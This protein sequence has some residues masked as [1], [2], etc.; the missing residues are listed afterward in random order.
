MPEDTKVESAPPS[1]PPDQKAPEQK[2]P[3]LILGKFKS[4][5][6][7]AASY[8]S[9]EAKLGERKPEPL[10]ISEPQVDDDAGIAKTVE[11]VGLGLPELAAEFSKSGKLTDDQYAKFK[12]KGF[13]RAYV[14]DMAKGLV[15]Q[16]ALRASH[17]AEAVRSA[18]E[19][20]GGTDKLDALLKEAKT[21][22]NSAEIPDFERRINDPRLAS[23]AVR[24]LAARHREAV[25]AGKAKPLVEGAPSSGSS[26]PKTAK[27]AMSLAE[28]VFK[29]DP[30]AIKIMAEA[31]RTGKTHEWSKN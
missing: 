17:Q 6:D 16:E 5:E 24:D 3:D 8:K 14:D 11:S 31:R 26:M 25:G 1:P 10:K 7:L 12:A 15:A 28:R 21:F 19:A 2:P 18:S 13:G 9:L 30:E 27:E 23:G 29:G 20:A 4:V 22:L